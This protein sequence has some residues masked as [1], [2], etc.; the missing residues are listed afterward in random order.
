[1]SVR[2]VMMILL[3]LVTLFFCV[4]VIS[5]IKN[6]DKFKG[7]FKKKPTVNWKWEDKWTGDTESLIPPE[8][9]V[10]PIQKPEVQPEIQSQIVANSY[11]EALS[12]SA[13]LGKPILAFFTADW[14]GA[15]KT[16]KANTL[17]DSAVMESM[18][19]YIVVFVNTDAEK[20]VARKFGIQSLPTFVV[21]D[22]NEQ[23]S[24]TGIGAM[25][26]NAF[27]NWLNT[28]VIQKNVVQYVT[29]RP[30]RLLNR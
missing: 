14:C 13:E 12:K 6:N 27:V 9:S 23:V 20:N 16:M 24:K 22:S 2:S 11:P 25:N 7:M 29:I 21:M 28:T 4:M 10:E 15:C 19:N 8:I 26:A 1:M 3:V 18:K 5:D 17:T 30:L